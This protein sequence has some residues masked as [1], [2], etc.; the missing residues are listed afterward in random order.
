MDAIMKGAA[1]LSVA[2]DEAELTRPQLIELT[3]F[4]APEELH[5]FVTTL[6]H[7]RCDETEIRDMQPAAVGFLYVFLRGQGKM[8]F[9]SGITDPSYPVSLMTP[10][11][12]ATPFEVDG[13]FHCV[14]AALLP[15]GW[16][17]FTGLNAD[18]HGN[19]LYDAGDWLGP[20]VIAL[21]VRLRA[22]YG[23]G[24][25]SP[26]E[27]CTE[28]AAFIAARVGPINPRHDALMTR[29]SDWLSSS[30]NPPLDALIDGCGYSERQLQ[31]LIERY[32][33]VTPKQLVRKYRALRV[34]ALLQSP[35]T[36]DEQI[37]ELLNLFYDQSHLIREIRLF[38]GRTPARLG[39]S[40]KPILDALLDLRNFREITPGLAAIP[41]P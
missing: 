23:T 26:E 34:A 17:A 20:A 18:Q 15:R 28:I 8:H 7:F 40:E 11:A 30:L 5:P 37:A 10:S 9:T 39:D 41:K 38:A 32:Y 4:P 31:R 6:F 16:A 33:G 27:M 12:F 21:G 22:A 35:D 19:R 3:Y 13:P 1:D 36:S 29:I 25:M 14:G 24:A 2:F